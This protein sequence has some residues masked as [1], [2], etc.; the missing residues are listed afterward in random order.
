MPVRKTESRIPESFQASD[1]GEAVVAADARSALV[2]FITSPVVVG[3]ENVYVV[4]VTDTGLASS[5]QSFEWSISENAGPPNVQSTPEGEFSYVPTTIGFLDLTVRMLD[6]GN[7]QLGT[8][9]LAQGI[10]E[11]NVELE[12]LVAGAK[13]EPGPGISSPDVARELVNDHNPYYQSVQLQTPES[14]D[15]F[16]RFV[17]SMVFD[18]A[19]QRSA[20]DRKSHLQELAAS[21]NDDRANFQTL[22]AQGA[23]VCGVRLAL[24]AMFRPDMLQFTELPEPPDQRALADEDLREALAALDEQKLIDLFNLVRFP[25][26]NITQC[27]RI[28]EALRDHYFPGTNFNDVI[29]GM[30]ATRL[31]WI[32]RHFREG[33]LIRT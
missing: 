1:F 28:F 31:H 18:G 17:Y 24:L 11:P 26:S 9:S 15:A 20:A 25:K 12:A 29:T 7:A 32:I 19:L 3:R 6:S 14:G 23:G 16:K 27:A 22:A 8:L 30:S 2:S 13:N 33:P 4:Y 10:V 21:L 5:I